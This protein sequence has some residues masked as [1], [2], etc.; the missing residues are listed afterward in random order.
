MQE[1]V[2]TPVTV[3]PVDSIDKSV[4]LDV[5]G[6]HKR[7]AG[8]HALK[9]V[10]VR[11]HAG[12][13]YHLLGE[14]GCGKSTL[15]KIIS[16]AQPPDEGQI[17]IEGRAFDRLSP[18]QS[19]AAGIE[20]VYQDLS[21]IPNLTVAENIG[22][23]EQ[24]VARQGR[25]GAWLDR[26]LLAETATRALAA[27][28][29]PTDA[30]F[31]GSPV[32]ELPIAWRQLIAI[33]RAI[34]CRARMVIMDEPTTALT[35]REVD[36][37]IAVVSN[38]R[39]QGVAVL[40]VSHKLDECYAIGGQ[41]IVFRDGQKVTQG[42]IADYTKADLTRLMTGKQLTGERYRAKPTYGETLLELHQ[43]G[44][45]GCFDDVS[46]TLARGEILGIT[47]LLDSGRNEL[48]LALAGVAPA[49]HGTLRIGGDVVRLRTPGDA[50]GRGIGYVPEDR[51]NEGLFLDKSIAENIVIAVLDRLR[52]RF[53]TLDA[54]RGTALA[55]ETVHDL[56]IAT[57][58]VE[59]PVQSL[60]GGNQQ[61]VLIGRW[62]TIAP[63]VLILHGPT[64]GVDVGSKD[65]IY[66]I[67]QRQAAQGLAVILISDDL[68]ELL[69]NC[70]RILL[71][72]KGRLTA[73]FDATEVDEADLY[74]A[75]LTETS[76]EATP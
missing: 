74:R 18:L 2:E 51:L 71:M 26:R 54:S 57:P 12:G 21:L 62:L 9:G 3:L 43:L 36:N 28:G 4:F 44:R 25:L 52:G 22:L 50:I 48:A 47:G 5:I 70:D 45:A 23:T 33:A 29:L 63:R 61:R 56:Q 67:V 7:F 8:V 49:T 31:R 64:V 42:P 60:S 55:R 73:T 10:S 16:G 75:L 59:R 40:F 76:L 19:L 69:Q 27:V 65:T 37:L 1:R 38:L 11:I 66:R 41:V 35:K 34:A 20:T 32:E 13:I 68:P 72:E 17:V 24:L 14:N 46:F 6:V 39:Q 30:A 53:G 58:D 15:I